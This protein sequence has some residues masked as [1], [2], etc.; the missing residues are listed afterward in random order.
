MPADL[1]ED[2]AMSTI[3]PSIADA[4]SADA[5]RGQQP[6]GQAASRPATASPCTRRRGVAASAR[7]RR[8]DWLQTADPRRRRPPRASAACR[9]PAALQA[10]RRVGG[11]RETALQV[12]S[13]QGSGH[14][15]ALLPAAVRAGRD[16]RRAAGRAGRICEAAPHVQGRAGELP[17]EHT[18]AS[19]GPLRAACCTAG[20]RMRPW[21]QDSRQAAGCG[22]PA[23]LVAAGASGRRGVWAAPLGPL[24]TMKGQGGLA[25]ALPGDASLSGRRRAVHMGG[26]WRARLPHPRPSSFCGRREQAAPGRPRRL[27]GLLDHVCEASQCLPSADARPCTVRGG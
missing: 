5:R 22:G 1:R 11:Q 10:E 14:L 26:G 12:L 21:S 20:T 15:P 17:G 8:T 7:A 25:V 9:L 6:H 27:P 23:A 19:L 16:T 4:Q 13:P 2:R 24:P 18:T 3:G